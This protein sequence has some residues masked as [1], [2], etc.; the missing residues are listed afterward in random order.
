[1][2]ALG[3]RHTVAPAVV[4]EVDDLF[5]VWPSTVTLS[6]QRCGIPQGSVFGPLLYLNGLAVAAVAS[7]GEVM[8]V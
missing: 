4:I 1:M 2:A 7:G 3:N 8:A 6:R 5:T